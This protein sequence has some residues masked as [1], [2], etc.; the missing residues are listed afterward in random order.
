M[1]AKGEGHVLPRF[2]R[3]LVNRLPSWCRTSRGVRRRPGESGRSVSRSLESAPA[4]FCGAH[5]AAVLGKAAR[6]VVRL[7][8]VAKISKAVNDLLR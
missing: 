4:E 7:A 5:H 8:R 1:T 6:T 2:A 3:A